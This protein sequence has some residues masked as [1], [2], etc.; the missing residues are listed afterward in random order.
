MPHARTQIRDAAV[1]LLTGL[2]TTGANIVAGRVWK[3]DDSKVAVLSVTT[4]NDTLVDDQQ[5]L[6]SKETRSA[7]LVIDGE[8]RAQADS[9][10]TLD[11]IDAEVQTALMA[12]DTLGGLVKFLEFVS[13]EKEISEDGDRAAGK[14][15]IE[16][17]FVYRIDRTAPIT[18]IQ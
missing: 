17:E 12:D 14:V 8:V 9:D 5:S 6:D 18:I 3:H 13:A 4:N 11:L 15:S 1:T 10:A 16:Y 2:T 7:R